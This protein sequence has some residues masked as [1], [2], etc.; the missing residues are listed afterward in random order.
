MSPLGVGEELI[1]IQT[2]V[3]VTSDLY[4]YVVLSL[5]MTSISSRHSYVIIIHGRLPNPIHS[6]NYGS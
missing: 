4:D 3:H 6:I 5:K 1:I 2:K